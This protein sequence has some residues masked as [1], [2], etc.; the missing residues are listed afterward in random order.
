MTDKRVLLKEWKL[1]SLMMIV[2]SLPIE[3]IVRH[4]P[5]ETLLTELLL[6]CAKRELDL[7]VEKE[8]PCTTITLKIISMEVTVL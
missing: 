6:K 2:L 3:T 4:W 7:Q 8:D 5:E 1:D